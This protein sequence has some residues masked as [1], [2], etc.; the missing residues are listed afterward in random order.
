MP[1][2]WAVAALRA[3]AVAARTYAV[4]DTVGGHGYDLFPDQR[5]QVYKGADVETAATDAAVARTAGQVVTYHGRPVITYFFASS[6][7]RTANVEDSFPGAAPEPWLV[8]VSDPYEG[9]AGAPLHRWRLRFTRRQA[10]AK[11]GSLVKG[12]LRAIK[13]TR[14]GATPRIVRARVRGSRGTTTATG[15]QL[16]ND[17][18]LYST[19][20]HLSVRHRHHRRHRAGRSG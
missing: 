3:Q 19:W 8:S 16:R 13:V 12:R 4:T 7:G 6:G 15:T 1:A 11:L 14:H 17:L 2:S 18:G 20:A 10:Q 5:S 9:A